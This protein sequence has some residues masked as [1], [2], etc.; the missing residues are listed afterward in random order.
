MG[1]GE[2]IP[3]LSVRTDLPQDQELTTAYNSDLRNS[4]IASLGMCRNMHY[5]NFKK[6]NKADSRMF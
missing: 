4:D 5:N 3:W 1:A 2:M 6:E